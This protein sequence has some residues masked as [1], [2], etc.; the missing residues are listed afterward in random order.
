MDIHEIITK[1]T[2]VLE[3]NNIKT[4]YLDSELL[5]SKVLKKDRRYILL[6]SKK[7]LSKKY[8]I[9]FT[10]LICRRKKGEPVAYLTNFKEFWKQKYFINNS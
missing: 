10:N 7:I 5:L 8:L 2:K 4:P 1:A 6:N 9:N 3:G